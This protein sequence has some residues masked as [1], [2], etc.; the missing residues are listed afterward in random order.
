VPW[1][2]KEILL[3]YKF[4]TFRVSTGLAF[5]MGV[6]VGL[7]IAYALRHEIRPHRSHFQIAVMWSA[8]SA[9]VLGILFGWYVQI[10]RGCRNEL[11]PKVAW[12]VQEILSFV[13]ITF[14]LLLIIMLGL[15]FILVV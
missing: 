3:K 7:L 10:V 5:I 14:G 11:V 6:T 9:V 4:G 12:L 8:G 15:F 2:I 1:K 13:L